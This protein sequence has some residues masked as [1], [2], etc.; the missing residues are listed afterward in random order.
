[1]ASS[2]VPGYRDPLAKR[3]ERRLS[4]LVNVPSHAHTKAVPPTPLDAEVKLPAVFVTS[5]W[6]RLSLA[7]RGVLIPL[8]QLWTAHESVPYRVTVPEIAARSGLSQPTVRKGIHELEAI[9]VIT[10]TPCEIGLK[11][12]HL[13]AVND[14]E[15]VTI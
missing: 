7:A 4:G 9:G 8:L 1:M 11:D 2:R 6:P 13:Y 3:E 5:V 15:N 12:G 10:L 14:L